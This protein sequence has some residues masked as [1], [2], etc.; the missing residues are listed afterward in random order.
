[1][2]KRFAIVSTAGLMTA[3]SALAAVDATATTDLNLRA[4][5]S[6]QSE[7]I[8]VIPGDGTVSVEQCVTDSQWCKVTMPDG[9]QGWAYS[10]YLTSTM[11]SEPV[12]VYDNRDALKIEQV[13]VDGSKEEGALVGGTLAGTIAAATVGGPI[14]AV[15]A[16]TVASGALGAA[17]GAATQPGDKVVTY[18]RENPS[19]PVYLN[20]EVVVGASL[21]Q[22]VTL[23]TVPDSEYDYVYINGVPAL[24]DPETRQV[25]SILR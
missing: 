15:A 7:V 14:G 9:T 5:P 6:P 10:A 1:M 2:F 8:G 22:D 25:V 19:E 23:Q 3:T 18:I 13:E 12:V 16:A 4:G 20:G 17:V 21:P 11:N 24:I